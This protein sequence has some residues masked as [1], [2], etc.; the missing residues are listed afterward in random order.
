MIERLMRLKK[1]DIITVM[2]GALEYMERYNGRSLYTC[3]EMSLEDFF[4]D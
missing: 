1:R 4:D 3:L 2:W